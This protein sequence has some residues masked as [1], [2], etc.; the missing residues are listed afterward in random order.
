MLAFI[1]SYKFEWGFLNIYLGKLILAATT[2]FKTLSSFSFI[3]SFYNK[4]C[5]MFFQNHT[6][7]TDVLSKLTGNDFYPSLFKRITVKGWMTW[8][9]LKNTIFGHV[10][11]SYLDF[12][13]RRHPKVHFIY[14]RIS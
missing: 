9:C 2:D 3:Y 1:E 14:N 6:L 12:K 5:S 8:I 10:N 4:Q 11:D 13:N 7:K